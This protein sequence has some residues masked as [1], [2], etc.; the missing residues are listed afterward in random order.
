MQKDQIV[1]GNEALARGLLESGCTMA[2]SYPGTPAS[3]IMGAVMAMAGAE[4]YPI[5]AE[6]SINEKVAFET[7]LA[8]AYCG[9]RAAVSMKQ[10]GLNVAAD[11]F[12]SA[13]YIGVKGGFLVIAADDPGPHSSQ[14]E[15]DSRLMAMLAKVPV[16][17]PASP[18]EAKEMVGLGFAL[19]E[20]Y[21]VP[22][23]I[24]P[25]TR[26]CHARQNVP[27]Q[28]LAPRELAPAFERNPGRWAATP[29]F[30][31][32]LHRALN[33]KLAGIAGE[34][35]ARLEPVLGEGPL[36]VVA[37][38]VVLAHARELLEEE[39]ELRK[40]L[41]LFR[42][43][44]PFPLDV[45][46]A[47]EILAPYPRVLVLE[48]SQPVIEMQLAGRIG[49]EIAGRRDGFWP[50]AGEMNPDVVA[51]GLLRFAG[52][53]E[54]EA[55]A[56]PAPGRRPTLC[57]GCAH[58]AAFFAL[59]EALPGGIYPSDIGCYT[60][61]MNMGA[62][63]TCLCMGGAVS[64]A[65]GFAHT[66]R[67]VA[68]KTPIG[69]TIGDS[70]FF[71]AGVPALINAVGHGAPI[72]LVILDNGTTAMTGHQPTPALERFDASGRGRAVSLEQIV[73][74]CGVQHLS[75]GDPYDYE[76][77]RGLIRDAEAAAEN[78]PAVVI[79]RRACLMDRHG[80][81]AG[82]GRR[83]T[84][85]EDCTACGI[86]QEDF[87]CPAWVEGDGGRMEILEHQCTGCGVCVHVCPMGAVEEVTA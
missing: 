47:R 65:A 24:R 43:R 16:L 53:P 60:L 23:L 7:A 29:K 52:L 77:F 5:H 12:L 20:A 44:M 41:T 74:G 72:V 71:H 85:N 15:Q 83:F 75:V 39:P 26:V 42:S 38:G 46:G 70:T 54:P 33:G 25:T 31:L 57:A 4:R 56:P 79:A 3:E 73:R 68:K 63:D 40:A 82:S 9:G 62:V 78:G 48:E 6:W 64:M 8:H 50:G 36:A 84:V 10:V 22:V 13:A 80:R 2:A 17:D 86:C 32:M 45:G 11:P 37:S 28:P 76:A 51:A 35:L 87:G 81:P 55:P 30:R 61:G 58:R 67:G 66:F 49:K 59:K 69:A 27:F 18:R 34:S 21:E 14:T 19:S 1:M